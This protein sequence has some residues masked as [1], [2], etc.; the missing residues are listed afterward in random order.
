MADWFL[1]EEEK[2]VNGQ[3]S[4]IF[5]SSHLLPILGSCP[6]CRKI[7]LWGDLITEL[8]IRVKASNFEDFDDNTKQNTNSTT[9]TTEASSKTVSVEPSNKQ[10]EK[11]VFGITGNSGKIRKGM[12]RE[13]V[14]EAT[15]LLSSSQPDSIQDDITTTTNIT[16]D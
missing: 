10:R 15:K 2:R 9:L 7:L 16:K 4:I 5:G 1:Q 3:N 8:N 14:K 12:T 6:L 11:I 13:K